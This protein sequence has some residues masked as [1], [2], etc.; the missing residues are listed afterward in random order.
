MSNAG[1]GLYAGAT[2]YPAVNLYLIHQ[3]DLA[4]GIRQAR[5]GSLIGLRADIGRDEGQ[6]PWNEPALY[7][8][9]FFVDNYILPAV[10]RAGIGVYDFCLGPNENFGE[11][12]GSL[13]YRAAV[14][15]RIMTR[16][17]YCV[18]MP[19]W[20]KP[21]A[22]AWGGISVGHIEKGEL[23]LFRDLW[24][25]AWAVNYHG[26]L[27]DRR[28]TLA[29]ETDPYFLWRPLSLWLPS[30][31]SYPWW[32]AAK[33][34]FRI[35]LGETGPKT[36]DL[37]PADGRA[38]LTISIHNAFDKACSSS[39]VDFVG[40]CAYGFGLVGGDNDPNDQRFWNLNGHEGIFEAAAI[41][42]SVPQRPV[43]PKWGD[44]AMTL[45]EQYRTQY[46]EWVAAGGDP[47]GDFRA[48]LV[49][50]GTLPTTETEMDKLKAR[51]AGLD[52]QIE[53][54]ARKLGPK[55]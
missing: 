29:Q 42:E 48:H 3:N 28:V 31:Q 41:N 39:G 4:P 43:I 30:L 25:H 47:E 15:T 24:L 40:V 19:A 32:Q 27:G 13:Q 8:A 36:C 46:T 52:Q 2:R 53:N 55:V 54:T 33:R 34:K 45:S 50:T 14:E 38:K 12:L 10:Q 7:A 51:R 11:D 22:Y 17:Q 5:P 21:L 23:V 9:D 20:W 37:L 35:L 1:V 44:E 6:I 49:G 26:Y 16:V 18:D